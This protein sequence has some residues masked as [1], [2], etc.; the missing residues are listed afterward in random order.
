MQKQSLNPFAATIILFTAMILFSNP[1]MANAFSLFKKSPQG[2][3]GNPYKLPVS[4][5]IDLTKKGNKLEVIIQIKE[6]YGYAFELEY[7]Y[8]D[9]RRSK[10]QWVEN[11]KS[12]FPERPYT[13]EELK[14]SNRVRKL[15]DYEELIKSGTGESY[16]SQWIKHPGIPTPIHLIVSKLAEGGKEEVVFDEIKDPKLTSWGS[17]FRKQ[18]WHGMVFKVGD[19]YKVTAECLRD[20][21]ELYGTKIYLRIARLPG[22]K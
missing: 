5:P 20:S 4:V 7:R 14:D 18:I 16:K 3:V 10:Y 2:T 6:P 1:K 9:P 22:A 11:L 21:P 17:D 12:F 8:D 19:I 15:I 13:E